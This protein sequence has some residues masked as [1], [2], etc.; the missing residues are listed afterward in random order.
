MR[1]YAG[2][3]RKFRAQEIELTIKMVTIPQTVWVSEFACASS[4]CDLQRGVNVN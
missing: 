3:N 2:R 1:P 4:G